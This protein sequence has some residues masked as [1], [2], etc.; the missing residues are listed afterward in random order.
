MAALDIQRWA[1]LGAQVPCWWRDQPEP[2]LR[3]SNQRT[4]ACVDDVGVADVLV[5]KLP[6]RL[7]WRRKLRYCR[8]C[9]T[10]SRSGSRATSCWG[11][12]M[13]DIG[14][15]AGQKSEEK[16]ATGML[17]GPVSERA[18]GAAKSG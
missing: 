7:W 13:H 3:S 11:W 4:A 14:S 17:T 12:G 15:P 8:R 5:T 18:A 16:A 10:G 9:M 6:T 1:V 2:E